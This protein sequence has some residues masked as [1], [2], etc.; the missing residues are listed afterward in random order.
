MYSVGPESSFDISPSVLERL[1]RRGQLICGHRS[2]QS[3]STLFPAG[4]K[5]RIYRRS[6]GVWFWLFSCLVVRDMD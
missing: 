5:I 4:S 1:K 2:G 3:E 6:P